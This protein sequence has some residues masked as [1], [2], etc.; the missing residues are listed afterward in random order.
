M[1]HASLEIVI[2]VIQSITTLPLH[3]QGSNNL[4]NV[5]LDLF[6]EAFVFVLLGS[7]LLSALFGLVLALGG[8]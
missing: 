5:L 1:G 8:S 3:N 2:K 4:L 6:L 7:H